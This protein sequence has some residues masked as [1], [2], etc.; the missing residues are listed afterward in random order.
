M[1][2]P[3]TDK[4]TLP[5]RSSLPSGRVVEVGF[6][7][8][9]G[10]RRAPPGHQGLSRQKPPIVP[11]NLSLAVEAPIALTPTFTRSGGQA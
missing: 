3:I 7:A 5:K 10:M 1:K 4:P 11:E 9:V 8:A 6:I 2:T